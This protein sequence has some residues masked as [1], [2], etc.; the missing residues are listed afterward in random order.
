MVKINNQKNIYVISGPSGVGKDTL[1]DILYDKYKDTLHIAITATTRKPR[2]NELNGVNHFFYNKEE[3]KEL[4]ENDS[5]IE[6]AIVYDNYYGVPYTEI[7]TNLKKGKKVLLR[8]DVQGAKR[9]KK[10]LPY[11][12]FIFISPESEMDLRL[13]LEKRHENSNKEIDIRIFESRNEA[14]EADW[15]DY[16]VINY[17]NKIK[18][19]VNEL[20]LLIGLNK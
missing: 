6:W 14:K 9:L 1:M 11:A 18:N 12:N 10:T 13:R 15:F 3:F 7:T 4:I 16:I 19:A 2:S 17:P 20:S 5:L 8:V